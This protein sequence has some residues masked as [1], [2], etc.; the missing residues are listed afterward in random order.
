MAPASRASRPGVHDAELACV[1]GFLRRRQL[2]HLRAARV[3]RKLV[4]ASADREH[5]RIQQRAPDR[6]GAEI[7]SIDQWF[8]IGVNDVY[9]TLRSLLLQLPRSYPHALARPAEAPIRKV[10]R[11]KP[12]LRAFEQLLDALKSFD[13]RGLTPDKLSRQ[14][15]SH[16]WSPALETP[17]F[18]RYRLSRGL[19]L[20]VN[21]RAKIAFAWITLL[22]WEDFEASDY[23]S[24]RAFSAARRRFDAD[25][26]RALAK[27]AARLGPPR[28]QTA[29]RELRS[30]TWPVR[31]GALALLQSDRDVAEGL[32]IELRLVPRHRA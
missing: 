29:E 31:G 12:R 14:C 24:S 21:P 23:A 4:L 25:F 16:G 28:A 27:V 5:V 30:A 8:G 10:V 15:A 26:E 19:F 6:W 13:L 18:T 32:T 7:F 9:P 1:E 17:A 22:V 2:S 20:D 3:G 11:P